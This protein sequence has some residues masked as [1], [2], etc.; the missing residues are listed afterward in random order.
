MTRVFINRG[1]ESNRV[2]IRKLLIEFYSAFNN[3][4]LLFFVLLTHFTKV[5]LPSGS[6]EL[7]NVNNGN[8]IYKFLY[9]I[10]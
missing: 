10:L 1:Q 9:V 8:T 5:S 6:E 7:V 4:F 3:G 2:T